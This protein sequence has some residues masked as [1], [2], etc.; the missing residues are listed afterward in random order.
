MVENV[1]RNLRYT[2]WF[3]ER[4]VC[5]QRIGERVVLQLKTD[6]EDIERRDAK[7]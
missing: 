2:Q 6:F 5:G 1:A 4:G 7:A 3:A